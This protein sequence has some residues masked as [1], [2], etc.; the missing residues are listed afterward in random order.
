MARDLIQNTKWTEFLSSRRYLAEISH[1]AHQQGRGQARRKVGRRGVAARVVCA[2]LC[3]I[4]AVGAFAVDDTCF[5]AFV[6]IEPARSGARHHPGGGNLVHWQASKSAL[7]RP[8]PS[9]S[10]RFRVCHTMNVDDELPHCKQRVAARNRYCDTV[11]AAEA[12][13]V[14]CSPSGA[15]AATNASSAM[16]AA[17]CPNAWG[18]SL[19]GVSEGAWW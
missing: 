18:E 9:P 8:P 16:P 10:L 1:S 2:L 11:T 4:V 12:S 14:H 17:N 19:S 6:V 3:V 13:A 15:S 7:L 5:T